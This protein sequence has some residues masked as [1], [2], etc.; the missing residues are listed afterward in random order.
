M[1]RGMV[2]WLTRSIS[3][4]IIFDSRFKDSTVDDGKKRVAIEVWSRDESIQGTV[5]PR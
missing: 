5:Y 1:L 3:T 4:K 2:N